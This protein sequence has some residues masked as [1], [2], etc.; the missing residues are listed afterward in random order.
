MDYAI[1][2]HVID[3]AMREV[4]RRDVVVAVEPKVFDLLLHLVENRRRVVSKDELV[5]R[6]WQGRTISD[7]ALSS[8]VKAARRAIGDDGR[9]QRLIRTIHRHGFRFVG[10]VVVNDQGPSADCG[11][12]TPAV[13][14]AAGDLGGEASPADGAAFDLDLSLPVRPSIA[15]LPIRALGG[16]DQ[17]SLLADGFT[18]DLTVRLARTRWLFVTARVSAARFQDASLDPA[19]IGERLG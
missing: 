14:P 1:E 17:P 6:I 3:V 9:Q 7:A 5:E 2:G 13:R 10:P 12:D 18:H 19:G 15:V 11:R 4:R 16:G 8:C